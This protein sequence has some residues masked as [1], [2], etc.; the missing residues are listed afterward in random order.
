MKS[1]TGNNKSVYT[2]LG[3]SNHT[4]SDRECNDFYATDP[5]AGELLLQLEDFQK[6][7]WEVSCGLGHLSKVFE[8]AG[9]IVKSTDLIDR[10]YGKGGI[11]FL[12]T[13]IKSWSGDIVTNPPYTWAKDFIEK[14]ISIVP[15]GNKIAMFLKLQFLESQN[16]KQ[17]FKNN[18]PKIVYV[19]SSRICCVKNGHFNKCSPNAIAY[20]WYIWIK[21]FK[22]DPIIK[23]FN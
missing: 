2:T 20:C 15:V 8:K 3:A 4:N 1:W 22:G 23:W 12:N 7:I 9:Y 6:N 5:K 11:D 13:T 14:A 19:S 17:F 21:G 18:P 16:R 10:G